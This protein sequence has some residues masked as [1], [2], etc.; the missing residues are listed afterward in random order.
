KFA[1]RTRPQHPRREAPAC[2]RGASKHRTRRSIDKPKR[3]GARN[4]RRKRRCRRRPTPLPNGPSRL[5]TE[6]PLSIDSTAD[7][8][9]EPSRSTKPVAHAREKTFGLTGGDIVPHRD[10]REYEELVGAHLYR[11]QI[12]DLV[13]ARLGRDR[14]AEP[15]EYFLGWSLADDQPA[16]APGELIR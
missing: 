12:D 11:P 3:S 1:H 8:R 4:R 9:Q 2:R 10:A 13:D 5:A 6:A 7:R 15:V 14:G 16:R